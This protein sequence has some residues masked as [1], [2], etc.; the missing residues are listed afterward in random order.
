MI[1]KEKLNNFFKKK[2][3]LIIGE[4]ILDKH[5]NIRNIGKSLET[6]TPKFAIL[7]KK[8]TLGGAG[9]VFESS[10]KITKSKNI[11]ITS[12]MRETKFFEKKNIFFFNSKNV[13]IIKNR[14]WLD[15]RKIIQINDDY[16]KKYLGQKK[17]TYFAVKI[18]KKNLEKISSIIVSDYN[19]NLINKD[20][21]EK[22]KKMCNRRA[23]DIYVDKQIR[24]ENE[25][26]MFYKGVDYLLINEFEFYL[27]K[28]KFKING[29]EKKSLVDIKNTLNIKN[30]ILKKGKKGSMMLN[31][32]NL[33]FFAKTQKKKK[34]LDVAGAGDYFLAM[35]ARLNNNID[36]TLRLKISNYWA[37]KNL[38]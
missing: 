9:K 13:N 36:P 4:L 19:H 27:L 20:L 11:L 3:I 38:K 6:D 16:K 29:S 10:N 28:K 24:N 8:T 17:F 5:Y 18:I 33:F 1:E 34:I 2:K 25:F 31:N 30:L 26:D 23:I 21:I 12:K 32:N 7:S 35:F 37:Y 14:Y 15:N 22:I